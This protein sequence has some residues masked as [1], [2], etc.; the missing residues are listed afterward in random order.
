MKNAR[1]KL[2]RRAFFYDNS[3]QNIGLI[4]VFCSAQFFGS[5]GGEDGHRVGG[6]V[7]GGEA[8]EEAF[9]GLAV[10]VHG[11][12]D[13]FAHVELLGEEGADHAG[14]DVAAAGGGQGGRTRRVDPGARGAQR[15]HGAGA[16]EDDDGARLHGEFAAGGDAVDGDLL[17][18]TAEQP[19]RL[20]GVRR[21]DRRVETREQAVLELHVLAD[22]VQAVGVDDERVLIWI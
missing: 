2:L 19:G 3:K 22:D 15:N 18:G 16:L 17:D 9:G 21:D 14:E 8:G 5:V 10:V 7:A 13:R 20:G 12:E 6:D 11:G 4:I 1:R